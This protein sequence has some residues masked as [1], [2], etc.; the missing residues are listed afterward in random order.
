MSKENQPYKPD[1]LSVFSDG[2]ESH[3]KVIAALVAKGYHEEF[4]AKAT[5]LKLPKVREYI[6]KW[7]KSKGH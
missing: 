2:S 4:I 6:A 1:S 7:R 3:Y 5:G